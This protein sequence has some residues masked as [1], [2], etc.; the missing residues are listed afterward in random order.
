MYNSED[1]W[2]DAIS[3]N[4]SLPGWDDG[5]KYE[6][7]KD[8][9]ML[10]FYY[11]DSKN[12]WIEDKRG[13]FKAFDDYKYDDDTECDANVMRYNILAKSLYNAAKCG[14]ADACKILIGLG[15]DN[16]VLIN[17]TH[18]ALMV[19]A[20]YGHIDCVKILKKHGAALRYR[21]AYHGIIDAN[22][23]ASANGYKL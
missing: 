4:C 16:D 10:W 23:L 14:N 6:F 19:A 5:G 9:S 17:K 13:V 11:D 18:T 7:M 12:D 20:E 21:V 22:E 2:I 15:A 8:L 3:R 1:A